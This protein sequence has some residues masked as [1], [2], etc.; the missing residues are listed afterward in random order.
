[1]EIVKN[2]KHEDITKIKPDFVNCV[3]R[4][5]TNTNLLKVIKENNKTPLKI[6]TKIAGPDDYIRRIT[7]IKILEQV[8]FDS[9]IKGNKQK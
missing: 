8:N 5:Q 1:M 6:Y 7:Q 9:L 2:L 3:V 4:N